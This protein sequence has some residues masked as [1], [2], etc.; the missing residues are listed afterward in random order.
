MTN[1]NEMNNQDGLS[2]SDNLKFKC[3]LSKKAI[4]R[5]ALIPWLYL[6]P[7]L[8]F[9]GYICAATGSWMLL[10]GLITFFCLLSAFNV[11]YT[12]KLEEGYLEITC[13]NE[14]KCKYLGYP[15]V[16]FPIKE[17]K[18]IEAISLKEAEERHARYPVVLNNKG[19]D[20]YPENG[21]LIT[22]NRSWIKSIFPLY[23]NPQDIEGFI[24][25]MR[26][27]MTDSQMNI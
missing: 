5:N 11:W 16:S 17:I 25:A 9:S 1:S 22:F 14:L 21:V 27:R 3:S 20:L 19:E 13:D 12:G 8:V 4:K 2:N 18:S 15:K 24:A 7:V 26:E 10:F 6:A 23:F